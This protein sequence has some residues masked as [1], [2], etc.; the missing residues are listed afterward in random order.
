MEKPHYS[1]EITVSPE[2]I[3]NLGHVNNAVYLEWVL[4][5]A[6]KHWF[7][8]AGAEDREKYRWIVRR[9]EIDYLKPAFLN[10]KLITTTWVE[11]MGGVQSQ[12]RVQIKRGNDVIMNALTRWVLIEAQSGRLTR[13]PEKLTRLYIP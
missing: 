1:L 2:H 6:G 8:T 9:H 4:M 5:M 12:R 3:D 11:D 7:A 10:E 13:I